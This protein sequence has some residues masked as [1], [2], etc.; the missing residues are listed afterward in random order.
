MYGSTSAP[1]PNSSSFAYKFLLKAS[2]TPVAPLITT[3][4]LDYN[5]N[6]NTA[7]TPTPSLSHYQQPSEPSWLNPALI[8][9]GQEFINQH[10]FAIYFAHLISL[11]FLFCYKPIRTI[12]LITQKSDSSSKALQRYFNTLAHIKAWYEGDLINPSGE[13]IQNIQRVR[14]LHCNLVAGFQKN[15]NKKKWQN[16][17]NGSQASQQ[18]ITDKGY[19]GRGGGGASSNHIV[20][21]VRKDLRARNK[22]AESCCYNGDRGCAGFTMN[23]LTCST[24]GAPASESLPP[25]SQLDMIITQFCFMGFV[26]LYPR[27]FGISNRNCT[28][29][30]CAGIQGKQVAAGSRLGNYS[31]HRLTVTKL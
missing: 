23:Y 18:Q 19:G 6:N 22:A 17:T 24:D 15:M 9:L 20:N 4:P 5:N 28:G 13:T 7:T 26:A 29:H 11:I 2:Q 10:F 25:I 8:K 30:S 14:K 1:T 12:L 16:K 3:Q 21:A 31:D 27:V